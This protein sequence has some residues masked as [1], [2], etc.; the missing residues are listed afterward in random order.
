MRWFLNDRDRVYHVAEFF[1]LAFSTACVILMTTQLKTTYQKDVDSFGA[2]HIPT[3][4]GIV[5]I[6]APC[7]LLAV[8]VHPSLN[9]HFLSDTAWTFSMYLESLAI[10][11]QLYM[12]QKQARGIVEVLVTHTTFA[13]GI[14]R[15]MDMVF[16]IFSYKE[17]TGHS[18]SKSV[19]VFVLLT[20]FVHVI[21]MGDF[22]YYYAIRC[23]N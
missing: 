14:A 9:R 13:V 6:V 8:L 11:P 19:G 5:Y 17:L 1:A 23:V 7:L 18:G 10:I 22:F 21:I 20:Q 16:W 12:F 4:F 3:E 15:V 2:L